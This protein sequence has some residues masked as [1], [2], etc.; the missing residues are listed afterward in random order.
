MVDDHHAS[1]ESI[2]KS[3]SSCQVVC[4]C[5]HLFQHFLRCDIPPCRRSDILPLFRFLKY[6]SEDLLATVVR[7]RGTRTISTPGRGPVD[8]DVPGQDKVKLIRS[9]QASA[10]RERERMIQGIQEQAY[11]N[12]ESHSAATYRVLN[13][14]GE[15][16]IS[17]IPANS[18]VEVR[19]PSTSLQFGPST[20]SPSRESR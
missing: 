4:T 13:G 18:E 11:S 16:D 1:W 2:Y 19:G 12:A 17:I 8:A 20:H 3:R 9:Q 6:S 14:F 10:S 15:D 5:P 7:E